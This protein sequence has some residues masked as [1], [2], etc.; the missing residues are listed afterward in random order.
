MSPAR[1]HWGGGDDRSHEILI[2]WWGRGPP[3]G[4]AEGRLM[5]EF[6]FGG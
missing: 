4:I 1:S 3:G 6:G 2:G 5:V